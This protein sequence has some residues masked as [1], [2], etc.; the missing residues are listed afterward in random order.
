MAAV[1]RRAYRSSIRRGDAPALVCEAAYRLFSTK[2]YLA[3]SIEDIAAEAGVARPTVFSAVGSKPVILRAVV[4]QA[5][6]GDD[7]PVPIAER[8]WWREAIEEPDP[9]R[10]I[11]LYARNMCRISGR[12]GLVLRALETA[13]SIDAD[14]AEVWARFQHQRRVGLK[15]FAVSLAHKT[16]T[17]RYD[18]DTITDTMWTLA[19]DAYLRLV[20][21]AG[22]PIERF[23]AWL[24][25]LLQRMFL[26]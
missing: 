4:D 3:T 21:D 16:S 6:A 25:D 2:G 13:A 18:E 22:W 15:E 8:P 14:A 1:K 12:A 20:H 5:L 19:P 23:Q 24:A 7:A 10:S 11:E 17:L 9:V 26:E